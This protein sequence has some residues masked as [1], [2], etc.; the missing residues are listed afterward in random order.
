MSRIALST[1]CVSLVFTIGCSDDDDFGSPNFDA[2][3]PAD[4]GP[5]PNDLPINVGD[6]FTYQGISR[7][8]N[9]CVNG[10]IDANCEEQGNCTLTS[11][12]PTKFPIRRLILPWVA[13]VVRVKL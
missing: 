10:F 1:L 6:L 13:P 7:T 9:G 4:A 12:S 3:P 2:G 11:K 8:P 5:A